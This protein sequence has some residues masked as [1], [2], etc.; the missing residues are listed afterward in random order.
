LTIPAP[1]ALLLHHA[2]GSNG[3]I[4]EVE[5]ALAPVH[6]WIERLDVFDDFADALNYANECLRSP[7]FVKRQL[8]L[9]AAPIPDY[10][11]FSHLNG[12]YRA[13]QHA[14]ISVIAEESEGLCHG[15]VLKHQGENAIRQSGDEARERHTSL[16]EYCWNH[17][18]LH[19]LKID[20]TLTYLQTAFNYQRFAEQILQMEQRFAG[21]VMSHIEFLRDNDG[22]ITASGLQLVRYS[23]EERLNEIMQIFRDNDIKINNPH[24]LQVEDG[25]QGIIRPDV[26][27]VKKYIDPDGLL[28][29]GKLRGWALRDQLVLDNN[30]L[31]LTDK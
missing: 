13:G 10:F 26:V 29:P 20:N 15:L 23:T 21:E 28:N 31:L 18:T 11:N 3:I 1:Q 30:P 17:T 25:K 8:A 22:N 9:L 2:Y 12:H 19:A 5:L 24:V 16:M 7:G 4:L 6:R 27:A 14:V